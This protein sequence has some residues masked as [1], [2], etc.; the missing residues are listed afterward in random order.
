M[1]DVGKES[2][3]HSKVGFALHGFFCWT[4]QGLL[5]CPM[6]KKAPVGL[7]R[8]KNRKGLSTI[9]Q[10]GDD[11][12]IRIAVVTA[13]AL[14]PSSLT[15][16]F[17]FCKIWETWRFSDLVILAKFAFDG[18]NISVMPRTFSGS[19]RSISA[20]A[21]NLGKT[22]C[23]LLGTIMLVQ[24]SMVLVLMWG[25][26]AESGVELSLGSAISMLMLSPW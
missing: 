25:M 4:F 17:A 11:L 21:V 14:V 24:L 22:T 6:N 12:A 13:E 18:S 8:M 9:N 1:R 2:S 5:I 16:I 15:S 19:F 10:G 26:M 20:V 7:C 3:L 23:T